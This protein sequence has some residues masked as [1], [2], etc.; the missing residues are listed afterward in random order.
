MHRPCILKTFHQTSGTIVCIVCSI[1]R[2]SSGSINFQ[3]RFKFG[4]PSLASPTVVVA[5]CPP[6]PPRSHVFSQISLRTAA[7]FEHLVD[8]CGK[9]DAA[10]L[11]FLGRRAVAVLTCHSPRIMRTSLRGSH[12]VPV[13]PPGPSKISTGHKHSRR[14]HVATAT[15]LF[16]SLGTSRQPNATRHDAAME[17]RMVELAEPRLQQHAR[18]NS[19]LGDSV[20]RWG[21][22]PSHPSAPLPCLKSVAAGPRLTSTFTRS[23]MIVGGLSPRLLTRSRVFW[24]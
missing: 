3:T 18:T 7:I 23:K 10:L 15:E 19:L 12:H 16:S 9:R 8:K 2:A 6:P 13:L 22:G 24:A 21:K 17:L 5:P 4:L 1:S 11:D 20:L 14:G